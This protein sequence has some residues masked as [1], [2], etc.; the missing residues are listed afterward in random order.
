MSAAGGKAPGL[1]IGER[2]G[3]AM[4]ARGETDQS[5]ASKLKRPDGTKVPKQTI[6]SI[7]AGRS[8]RSAYLYDICLKLGIRRDWLLTGEGQ[9][10]VPP[11]SVSDEG[12]AYASRSIVDLDGLP[13][14]LQAAIRGMVSDL[15]ALRA[16][17]TATFDLLF[18]GTKGR[19]QEAFEQFLGAFTQAERV[20]DRR[21]KK[22][23]RS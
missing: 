12:A 21:R 9:R 19:R 5:L 15:L 20:E 23:A 4:K 22:K 16:Q 1:A 2:L 18:R 13:E 17:H 14:P 7:R 11:L 8:A 10:D 3:E 6:Q